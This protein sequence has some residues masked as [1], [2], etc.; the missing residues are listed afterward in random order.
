MPAGRSSRLAMGGLA[1]I[2]IIGMKNEQK[3]KIHPSHND[4]Y[5][6]LYSLSV[7]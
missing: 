7:K 6:G 4:R 2:I 5:K 1:G 3:E